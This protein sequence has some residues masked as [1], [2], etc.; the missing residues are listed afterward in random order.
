[1]IIE[2]EKLTIHVFK[3]LFKSN[4]D[5]VDLLLN[6]LHLVTCYVIQ[7]Q[8]VDNLVELIDVDKQL[9]E[10]FGDYKVRIVNIAIFY[11]VV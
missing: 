5:K 8:F 1:L 7:S 3:L 6:L 10:V 9:L 2:L 4:I 11:Y